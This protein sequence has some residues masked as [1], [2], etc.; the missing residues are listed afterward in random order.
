MS[1]IT[2]TLPEHTKENQTLEAA[3]SETL[4]GKGGRHEGK[5]PTLGTGAG[6]LKCVAV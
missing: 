1:A 2:H 4:A 6:M 3:I 5:V